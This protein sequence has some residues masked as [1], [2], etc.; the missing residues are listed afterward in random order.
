[1]S[2]DIHSEHVEEVSFHAPTK[3][4]IFGKSEISEIELGLLQM[5]ILWILKRESTHGYE[6]M[7]RLSELK[8]VHITQG[9]MYPTLQRLE[10]LRY[11][12]R[13]EDG[14]KIIYDLTEKGKKALDEGCAS[15]TR[16]FFGIFHDYVCGK[17]VARVGERGVKE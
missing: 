10:E 3:D 9:T 1:M 6:I 4:E 12:K 13:R 7:K 8:N 2:P 16:T 5:Q 17:C 14:R 11:I 15:F